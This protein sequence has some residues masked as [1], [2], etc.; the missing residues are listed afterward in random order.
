[1]NRLVVAGVLAFSFATGNV[2]A[3]N[4]VLMA[5]RASG[6]FSSDDH[7][8]PV[9]LTDNDETTLS[10]S[11]TASGRAMLTYNASCYVHGKGNGTGARHGTGTGYVQIFIMVDGK[12]AFP[13]AVDNGLVLCSE[14]PESSPVL[15]VS[16]V[17]VAEVRLNRSGAH[18]VQ[19]IAQGVNT[20][21]W[22]LYSSFLSIA[23]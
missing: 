5:T 8:H 1:M 18:T 11:T 4:T 21:Q 14:T 2:A 7:K 22:G 16:A 9:P 6:L 12:H 17:R 23:Q 15:A 20:N 3:A 10:F 13:H 19:I